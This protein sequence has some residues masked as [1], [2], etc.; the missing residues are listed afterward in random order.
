VSKTSS[1]ASAA[2]TPPLRSKRIKRVQLPPLRVYNL[3]REAVERG[4]HGGINKTR[5]Y[6]DGLSDEIAA[7]LEQ[8]LDCYIMLELDELVVWPDEADEYDGLGL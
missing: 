8:H 3:I 5:K 4:I 7:S 6:H 2:A 1:K